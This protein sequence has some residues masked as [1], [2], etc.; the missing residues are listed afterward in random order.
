M[1]LKEVHGRWAFFTGDRVSGDTEAEND[2]LY[3]DITYFTFK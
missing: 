1:N 3:V 2:I